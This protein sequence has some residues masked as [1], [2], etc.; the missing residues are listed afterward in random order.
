MEEIKEWILTAMI[1]IIMGIFTVVVKLT[2]SKKQVNFKQMFALFYI[3]PQRSFL[4]TKR[5]AVYVTA[6]M[7]PSAGMD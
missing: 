3:M 5:I 1:F 7:D 2:K 6:G 4:A